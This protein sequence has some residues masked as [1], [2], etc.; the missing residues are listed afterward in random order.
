MATAPTNLEVIPI[1][2][3]TQGIAG[4]T[5]VFDK[6]M[7]ANKAH[8]EQ[9]F[10]LQRIRG[11]DYATVYL[12]VLDSTMKIALDFFV[13]QR[14]LGLEAALLDIQRQIALIELEKAGVELEIAKLNAQKIPAEIAVLEGQKCKLDAEYDVLIGQK[15]KVV[16]ETA[17]LNQ[18]V[19]S[20][21]AQTV[22]AAVDEDS[23]IGRQKLLYK[24]QTDGFTR[25]A[26][27]KVAKLLIDSWNVRRTT[28]SGTEANAQNLLYDPTIGRAVTK[29]LGGVNA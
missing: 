11:A 15:L 3:F 1:D 12:G 14:K 21:R 22:G 28:D 29:L 4:G 17:L 19:T 26:E 9:E 24:A 10:N 25:D 16:A 18:K 13:Q 7:V 6:L 8:L 23:V 2:E 5:G 27:Q 20:E